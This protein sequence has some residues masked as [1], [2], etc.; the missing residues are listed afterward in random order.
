MY[1]ILVTIVVAFCKAASL[2]CLEGVSD[3]IH[4]CSARL[5]APEGGSSVC[6]EVYSLR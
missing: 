4:Y 3:I 2:G 5:L 1:S 6:P